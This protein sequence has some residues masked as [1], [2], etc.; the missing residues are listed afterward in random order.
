MSIAQTKLSVSSS[1]E[2]FEVLSK[3]VDQG[4]CHA[5]LTADAVEQVPKV[6][7]QMIYRYVKPSAIQQKGI[8][9]F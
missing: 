3:D 5:S 2:H 4:Y 9:Q 8:R 7:A 6:K 1:Q